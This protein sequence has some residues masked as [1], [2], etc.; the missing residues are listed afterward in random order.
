MLRGF[1]ASGY[2][3]FGATPQPI[4]PLEKI[5]LLVGRNNVGKSNVLRLVQLL[6]GFLSRPQQFQ[7]P[8]GL[9][10]HLGSRSAPFAWHFPLSIDDAGV[11]YLVKTLLQSQ[12]NQQGQPHVATHW[13]WLIKSILA[14]LPS[15]RD[16]TAWVTLSNANSWK[17]DLPNPQVILHAIQKKQPSQSVKDSWYRLWSALTGSTG[18]SFDQHHGPVVLESLL[19]QA[20]PTMRRVSLLGAHRQIGAPGTSSQDI[21]GEGLIARLLEL[22]NPELSVRTASLEKFERINDFVAQVIEVAGARLEVPHSGK[23]LNV[24]IGGRVLPIESLGTGIHQVIIFAAAATSVD[25]EILCIEEPEIHLHPRLQRQLLRY[26]HDQTENQY[27]VT[28]HSACLLDS[29]NAALFHIKLNEQEESE[30]LKL[31]LPGHRAAAGFDLGYRAS[32]L[33]QANSIV[34]VEGPSDRIYV[35]AWIHK[36]APELSEGLHYSVMFYGGR[37]LSHL[38]A[39]DA[40]VTDFIALQRLNRHVAIIVDSD[41]R[42]ADDFLNSTK[43]RILDEIERVSGFGWVTSGREIENYVPME[44]MQSALAAVHPRNTFKTSKSQWSCCYEANDSKNFSVDKV[45]VARAATST[46]DLGQLDLKSKAESLV[47]FI[48]AA[49]S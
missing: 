23:E 13:N 42:K 36:L 44:T 1:A 3:S 14:E 31:H 26:L 19:L 49:N 47:A 40:S 39:D 33:V 8:S 46:V 24:S 22:Q 6:E 7:A 43:Q 38:T 18:G 2:R 41:K 30:V 16:G 28:T 45:A 17:P 15:A 37:L 35:N 12:Q 5:N 20:R 25:N 4:F 10:A 32:D 27:F 34:W 21:N 29:P 11:S 9:D 48:R